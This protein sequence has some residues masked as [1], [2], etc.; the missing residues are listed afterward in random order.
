[1]KGLMSCLTF[2]QGV[3]INLCIP[4]NN[5]Y[6][7]IF[8]IFAR[9]GLDFS[10][11]HSM[12]QS[13][14]AESWGISPCAPTTL[15][16]PAGAKWVGRQEELVSLMPTVVK[17]GMFWQPLMQIW[18]GDVYS[19]F[20]MASSGCFFLFLSADGVEIGIPSIGFHLAFAG[21]VSRFLVCSLL[22]VP[23]SSIQV[24][25]RAGHCCWNDAWELFSVIFPGWCH[26]TW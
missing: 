12:Y 21:I 22:Q 17:V 16:T 15:T 5:I 18:A 3:L 10:R 7:I 24:G 11:P 14:A 4:C 1:M 2:K 19:Q 20:G 26:W 9:P 23:W 8:W 6:R 13:E 25:L